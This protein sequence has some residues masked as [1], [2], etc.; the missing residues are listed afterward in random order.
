MDGDG[1]GDRI[2]YSYSL[3]QPLSF[4]Y[5]YLISVCIGDSVTYHT[6]RDRITKKAFERFNLNGVVLLHAD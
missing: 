3:K 1:D 2:F 5:S 6:D 4:F